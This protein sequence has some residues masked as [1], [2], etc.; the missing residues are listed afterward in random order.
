MNFSEFEHILSHKRIERYLMACHGRKR[1]TMLLY[2]QN[3]RLAKEMFVIVNY[4]E[5]ALRNA[6]D[7]QVKNILGEDWL[8][9]AVMPGGVFDNPKC[10][11][12]QKIIYA[13]CMALKECGEYSHD[14]LLSSLE[15]GIWRYMFSPTQ[16]KGTGQ[17]LLR[18]FPNKPKSSAAMQYNHVYFFNELN[19]INMLRNRIAHHE[20]ICFS[21]KKHDVNTTYI[22]EQYERIMR[23]FRMMGINS[24]KL[25]K[26]VDYVNMVCNEIEKNIIKQ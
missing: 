25:L 3:I 14:K 17:V 20:P 10:K 26:N 2:N 15:F 12:S 9:D 18:V 16:F 13:R 24:K 5:V 19:Y 8:R 1:K 22:H 23:L 7:Q 4:F 6:I 11:D 21:Q